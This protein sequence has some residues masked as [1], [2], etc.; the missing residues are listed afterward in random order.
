MPNTYRTTITL[1][2]Q[3]ETYEADVSGEVE[4]DGEYRVPDLSLRVEG[5]RYCVANGDREAVTGPELRSVLPLRDD[6]EDGARECLVDERR[7][8]DLARLGRALGLEASSGA[9]PACYEPRGRCGVC[10]EPTGA[11]HGEACVWVGE[12]RP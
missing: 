12:V 2:R 5:V 4:L 3:G 11:A 10:R 1:S 7:E 6:E 8:E 9:P